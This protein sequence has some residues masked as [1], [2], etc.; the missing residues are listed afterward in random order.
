MKV[1]FLDRLVCNIS[2]KA[3]KLIAFE[4]DEIQDG[5]QVVP[6]VKEGI[7]VLSDA[8]VWYPLLQ[9]APLQ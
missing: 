5:N 3:R 6:T 1:S 8:S 2:G 7:L 9:L 4:S